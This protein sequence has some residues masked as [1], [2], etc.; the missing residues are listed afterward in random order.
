MG[1]DPT[2]EKAD[3]TL[4]VATSIIDPIYHSPSEFDSKGGGEVYMMGERRGTPK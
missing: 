4:A 1:S 2:G 3:H